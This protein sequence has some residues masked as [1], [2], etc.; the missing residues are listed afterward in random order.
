MAATETWAIVRGEVGWPGGL[1]DLDG[2]VEAGT[3]RASTGAPARL[4]GCGAK[5]LVSDLDPEGAVTIVGARRATREGAACAEQLASALAAAGL[6]IVSGMAFGIDSAAHRGALAAGGATIAVLAGG[7]DIPYPP[8]ARELHRRILE[9]G[10]ATVAEAPPGH[11]PERWAFPARNR[12]MA[13]LSAITLVVE[14]TEP[15]GTRIT[16]DRA[17]EL[18]REV[19]AVPGPVSSPLKAGPHALIRDGAFLV[20]GAQD[21]LDVALGVGA[22]EA[23]RIG[24]AL[25][26]ALSQTLALVGA[27]GAGS[28]TVAARSDLE[29]GAVAVA[30]ARLELLG[31]LRFDSGRFVR[32]GLEP[33]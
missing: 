6:V 27:A 20:R 24:T 16:A 2:L 22:A 17:I 5:A 13:A 7:P 33:P 31:Y 26:P 10:G 12:I 19:G 3:A 11:R 21:V 23:R 25:E 9:S 32:T 30:L 1:A 14:A 15:S 4:Y 29:A 28:E 8:S 18:G